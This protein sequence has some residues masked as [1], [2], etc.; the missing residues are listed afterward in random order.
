MVERYQKLCNELTWP[1]HGGVPNLPLSDYDSPTKSQKRWH[2]HLA[3]D[4]NPLIIKDPKKRNYLFEHFL[5]LC[6]L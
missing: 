1:F 2:R 6:Q 3:C 4:S 5:H